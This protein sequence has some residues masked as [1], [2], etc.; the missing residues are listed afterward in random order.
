M[1]Q[2]SIKCTVQPVCT[3]TWSLCT[4]IWRCVYMSLAQIYTDAYTHLVYV[5]IYIDECTHCTH[6]Y[7]PCTY[8]HVCTEKCIR[9]ASCAHTYMNTYLHALHA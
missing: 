6:T 4:L 1:G 3:Y 2:Q 5:Y 9:Q 7:T 8:T